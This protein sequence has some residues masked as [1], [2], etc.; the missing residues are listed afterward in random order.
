MTPTNPIVEGMVDI[1]LVELQQGKGLADIL[2]SFA[3]DPDEPRDEQGRWS[4]GGTGGGSGTT[5]SKGSEYTPEE[6]ARLDA[7]IAADKARAEASSTTSPTKAKAARQFVTVYHGSA[8]AVG[9]K[10]RAEGLK[11]QPGARVWSDSDPVLYEG[12]RGNS[13]YVTTDED[14]A[15]NYAMEAA[16]AYHRKTF[17]KTFPL[18]VKVKVPKDEWEKGFKLDEHE[19]SAKYRVG[20]IPKEWVKGADVLDDGGFLKAKLFAEESEG[21]TA[22]SVVLSDLGNTAIKDNSLAITLQGEAPNEEWVRNTLIPFLRD[23]LKEFEFNPDEERDEQG[24][25]TG[26]SGSVYA[27]AG[28]AVDGFRVRGHIPNESSIDASLSDYEELSSIREVPVAAFDPEFV[29]STRARLQREA[30]KLSA[31]DKKVLDLSKEIAASK[32][33]NPLIVAVDKEGPY[34]I[35]GGHRLDAMIHLGAKAVPAK[36][37][38]DKQDIGD[39][40]VNWHYTPKKTKYAIRQNSKNSNGL[41]VSRPVVNAKQLYDWADK[42]NIPGIVPPEQMHVTVV[43]S[44]KN[45]DLTPSK[46]NVSINGGARSI[47]PLGDKGA[48]VL[49]LESPALQKRWQEAADAGASWDYES[50]YHPHV[51]LTY[52][53]DMGS[54]DPKK[55]APPDFDIELGPE[56]HEP[57]NDNWAVE[58]GLRKAEMRLEA[59]K[60]FW[61]KQYEFNEDEPRDETGKWTDGGGAGLDAEKHDGYKGLHNEI[62]MHLHQF[63]SEV[64]G[65]DIEHGIATSMFGGKAEVL[66]TFK[67]E[68]SKIDFTN[69]DVEALSNRN[70]VFTHNHPTGSSFSPEDILMAQKL[71]LQEMRAVGKD[72]IYCMRRV[73][74]WPSGTAIK[75]YSDNI[76]KQVYDENT[77]RI[78]DG[79]LSLD[80]AEANHWHEVWTRFEKEMNGKVAYTRTKR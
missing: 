44:R 30:S 77:P 36:V 50:G 57:I 23:E 58:Q 38:L 21:V 41:Y 37:V 65:K 49:K 16:A 12:E 80:A 72:Y 7:A 51:T 76:H 5:K 52:D 43:Y 19:P 42:N 53:A 4:E 62:A 61:A 59:V 17:R 70:A 1:A 35:E 13:V 68:E 9:D 29:N 15:V 74:N 3:F 27:K 78:M 55:L 14:L 8:K 63:E 56:K 64:A 28:A 11:P 71:D 18:L 47:E 20:G 34:I 24:R 25:W 2:K 66:R 40:P 39:G 10:I 46:D 32:E 60:V 73:D 31:R 54:F 48:V 45:V 75:T 22:W 79:T 26:G 33:I 6:L 69:D 67:G